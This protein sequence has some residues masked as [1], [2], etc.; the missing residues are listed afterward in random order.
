MGFFGKLF[1]TGE[2]NPSKRSVDAGQ[3]CSKCGQPVPRENMA[4]D[5]GSGGVIHR[6]CP[7]S[8]TGPAS[9]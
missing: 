5:S 4:F 3:K 6:K 2:D 9:E 1:G 7:E 8:S